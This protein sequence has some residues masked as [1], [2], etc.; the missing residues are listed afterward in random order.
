VRS[1]ISGHTEIVGQQIRKNESALPFV[2]NRPRPK[3]DKGRRKWTKVGSPWVRLGVIPRSSAQ[4]GVG[5]P[6]HVFTGLCS[7]G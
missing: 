3:K 6:K 2:G 7:G 1:A 5:G 4:T